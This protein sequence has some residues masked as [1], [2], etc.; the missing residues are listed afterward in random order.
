M[1]K[2]PEK[3]FGSFLFFLSCYWGIFLLG[4]VLVYHFIFNKNRS[5][6]L[7]RNA[8]SSEKIT[9]TKKE[10]RI[11]MQRVLKTFSYRTLQTHFKTSSN[12][13]CDFF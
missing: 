4:S 3:N 12:S 11:K 2:T 13:T 8:L 5:K 1:S 6:N 9:L 10:K 7:I